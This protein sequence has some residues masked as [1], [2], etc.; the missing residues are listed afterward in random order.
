MKKILNIAKSEL[1]TMF[2]SPVAWLILIVFTMQLGITF[3]SFL[4]DLTSYQYMGGILGILTHTL[5]A[6][7][8][9]GL[10]TTM[11]N[12]LYLY[13]P[14]L[15]MGLMSREYTSGSIRL[16]YSSPI[17]A[18]DIVIGKF[19]GIVGFGLTLIAMVAILAVGFS[20]TVENFNYV[21]MF[22]GLLGMFLLI[23]A[24]SAIGLFVSS[25][26]A[27]QVVAAIGT[28]VI[29]AIL[30]YCNQLWQDIAFVRDI[31]YWLCLKG[32]TGGMVSG[33]ICSEDVIYFIVVIT[34]FLLFTI[35]KV[36]S[37]RR[38]ERTYVT[39]LR[40][41]GL[42]IAV[43]LVGYIT[44]RP[45]M[46]SYYD[47][48]ETKRNTLSVASQEI[49]GKLEGPVT[50]TTYVNYLDDNAYM[51]MPDQVMR[52][53]AGYEQYIRFKPD[54]TMKYVYYYKL[55]PNPRYERIYAGMS[56]REILEKECEIHD[57]NPDIFV[58]ADQLTTDA[59]LE[60]EGYRFF[61]T[62]EL[63]D[64][65]L[66]YLRLY[67][68]MMKIPGETEISIAFKRFTTKMPI[69]GFL[70]GH[71]EPDID[72]QAPYA[73]DYSMFA[74]SRTF[75]QSL[76]NQG[77][78]CEKVSVSGDDDIP[79]YIDILVVADLETPMTSEEMEK[80][81]R[82]VERGGNL[83]VA[84]K[85]RKSE[86][87]NPIVEQFG[88]KFGE[89]TLIQPQRDELANVVYNRATPEM[90]ALSPHMSELGEP[91]NAFVAMTAAAPI[92][93]TAGH[94]YD[95][96]PILYTDTTAT[97]N[98][99]ETNAGV[100]SEL[101]TIDYVNE[102]PTCDPSTGEEKK[103]YIT[104]VAVTRNVGDKEQRIMILS[105]ASAICNGEFSNRHNI[106]N[107]L[108]FPIITGGFHWFSYGESPIDVSH[109]M[110]TDLHSTFTKADMIWA[111]ILCLGVLP[112]SLLL[113]AFAISIRRQ[114]R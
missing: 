41:T 61:R 24:Y 14:L 7:S 31:T 95:I 92:E 101:Q 78:D 45:M 57:I 98:S 13:M 79:G 2:Y 97:S 29:L 102:V 83:L 69:V 71:G 21:E 42:I 33:I 35:L 100:W 93:Y 72:M 99:S 62:I 49:M 75:R 6:N 39:A 80:F 52:D 107:V 73:R 74:N 3:M 111:R 10:L 32:R 86:V 90:V 23:C 76:V 27:Y 66:A 4:K 11:Q 56:E 51:G 28:L 12:Y 30:N 65:K 59:D 70:S 110:P 96:R 22:S 58:Q 91:R 18:K 15:T 67:N 8:Q 26:T 54:I 63:A 5:M 89:G 84:G 103:A 81:N 46:K 20:F 55:L 109:P 50:I 82:Y 104:G 106:Y 37:S 34:L 77:F 85:A 44:S 25:L 105:D 19:L 38:S 1:L 47:T 53:L 108:N 16:L 64:G 68:D 94:G 60:G 87:M 9:D 17:T 113:L 88:V 48:T 36:Q 43:I 112:G 114:R 40:Y